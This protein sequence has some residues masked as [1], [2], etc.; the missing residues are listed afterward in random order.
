MLLFTKFL[1]MMKVYK[2]ICI[3]YLLNLICLFDHHVY[4]LTI[5]VT[6]E[7]LMIH[8]KPDIKPLSAVRSNIWKTIFPSLIHDYHNIWCFR[9]D[10]IHTSLPLYININSWDD[11]FYWTVAIKK[12]Y[13]HVRRVG[14]LPLVPIFH[15]INNDCD[16]T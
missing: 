7:L 4:I 12:R 10:W 9:H 16:C 2:N 1:T 15:S 3:R 8:I 5:L 14:L 13:P 11:N 6:M